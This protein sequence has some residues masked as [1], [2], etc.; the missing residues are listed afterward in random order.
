M[1]AEEVSVLPFDLPS[2]WTQTSV[3]EEFYLILGKMLD[4]EKNTGVSRHYLGNKAVQWGHIAVEDLAEIKLTKSD[5]LRYRLVDGDLLVC[6]GGDIGRCAIW[7]SQLEE[8][9]FQKALHRVR[10]RGNFSIILLRYL[11]EHYSKTGFLKNFATQTSI[12]HLPKDKF[13]QVPLPSPPPAEQQ[14]IA[15]ALLDA[16]G[17]VEGLERLI[18][19]KQRIKQG[20]M[21]DLLTAKRRLP[22]FSG[23]WKKQAIGKITDVIMGQSPSSASY[24]SAGTGLPLIQGAADIRNRRVIQR[25]FT[26]QITKLGLAGDI[27]MT[28]RAPVGEISETDFDVCLGR[29]VCALRNA[30]RYVFHA[31]VFYETEWASLSKGSTFDSVNGKEVSEFEILYSDQSKEREAI[32]NLLDEMDAEI[33]ALEAR[34]QKARQIKEGMMQNLLTGRIRLV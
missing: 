12:A 33:T 14:A 19:K 15:E 4:A 5:L 21:Q 31:M 6:E 29:G 18:E 22:G 16:D 10:T 32:Y 23:K 2:G 30:D 17:V 8:C 24:N 26:S 11:L 7:H 1:I 34:L 3:D 20:A 13:Q 25:V 9:Y 28:V 27:V